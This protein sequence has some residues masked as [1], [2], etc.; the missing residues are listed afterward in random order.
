MAFNINTNGNSPSAIDVIIGGTTYSVS[1]FDVLELKSGI[2]TTVWKTAIEKYLFD[3][4]ATDN[5]TGNW[6]FSGNI[7]NQGD[8]LTVGDTIYCMIRQGGDADTGDDVSGR[9]YSDIINFSGYSTLRL[10][11]TFY[12]WQGYGSEDFVVSVGNYSY[13][14]N[15]NYDVPITMIDLDISDVTSGVISFDVNA[16]D[17][18]SSATSY[19]GGTLKINQ[20]ILCNPTMT[21]EHEWDFTQSLVDSIDGASTVTLYNSA[22]RDSNGIKLSSA[23]DYI[24]FPMSFETGYVYE[25]DMGDMIFKS[26]SNHGRFIMVDNESGLIYRSADHWGAWQDS[27]VQNRTSDTNSSLFA[28]STIKVVVR[29][30]KSIEFYHNGEYYAHYTISD[31]RI[32]VSNFTI[33][34][35]DGQSFYNLVIK[36]ARI[37]KY[38]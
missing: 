31:S 10:V 17:K 16:T 28:N 2:T 14:I 9:V 32:G 3:N 22:T 34:S 1:R 23:T 29:P 38:D 7:G 33:G 12:N 24:K 37:Y 30:D 26:S 21:L 35:S 19:A 6:H 11:G 5:Y 13:E 25:F 4:G 20:I 8:A 15:G 27:W 36:A 18:S